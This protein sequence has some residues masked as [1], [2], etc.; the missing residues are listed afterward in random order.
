MICN[1]DGCT[2][3][4]RMLGLMGLPNDTTMDG[5]SFHIIEE[6]IGP[7]MRQ[8]TDEVLL[9]N[10][11]EEVRLSSDNESDFETWKRSIDPLVA[12]P[13][14]PL[15]RHPRI[16]AS[17]DTAWQQKGSGHTHNSPSGHSLMF[18]HHTRKPLVYA[19]K[20]KVCNYCNAFKKKQPNVDV[21]PHDCCKNHT[22]SS[23]QMEPD[24][25]LQ[26]IVSLFDRHQCVLNMLCCDDDSSVRADCRWSN[27]DFLAN[28]PPGTKLPL[29]KK[30]VGKNKGELQ[31]RPN[32]G[33]LPA[34][35]PEPF[36]VADP[37][38]RRK[39]LTGELI[40]LAKSKVETKMTMTRMD[41]TRIGK[42]FGYMA[43]SLK[44]TPP[45]GFVDKGKAV[46]EH[47]FDNHEYCGTWCAR[48]NESV[49]RRAATKKY[50][51]CKTKDA[52]LYCLLE[53]ILSNYITFERL[54]DIAHGMDTNCCEAFNNF[55]TWF[56]PKNKV[57]C[58]SRSLWNR[59]GLCI[60][61]SSLGYLV[62]F[63]RLY[64]KMGI[65]M[66]PNVHNF[67]D[68]K[69]RSR[70]KRL[71]LAKD[72]ASKKKRNKRKY[73]KL[74]EY[75]TIARKERSKRDGYRTGMN[76][77]T[78]E[79]GPEEAASAAPAAVPKKRPPRQVSVCPHPFC[80]KRGHKTTKSKH[81]L[82]NPHRLQREGLESA[83]LAA[84]AAVEEDDDAVQPMVDDD[85]NTDAA[86][87]L[88]EYE[89][90]PFEEFEEDL[91]YT[92]GTWSEDDDGNVV[93]KSGV[94]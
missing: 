24:S 59:V 93:L 91:F 20:S 47:H 75:T 56:A 69:N 38:H 37:N 71:A 9:E 45:E 48:Q 12:T 64:K 80:G 49:E 30:K 65:T 22:G 26:L 79:V 41:A 17:N 77:D 4:A 21:P 83:C 89:S 63:Q 55:M 68:V 36:F 90:Q 27:P 61:I 73:D 84:V 6:R 13:P 70:S 34:R 16:N 32:K 33:K 92:S 39:Q 52:K 78:V 74:V 94:I 3:A 8:L 11:I 35:I 44:G 29:V 58:G 88:A 1:G 53:G 66:E 81:C 42:N 18:G 82:A 7:L 46:L 50:Y 2:E 15:E 10:L 76:L 51:R 86:N 62:Y 85:N 40:A 14:L 25:C 43:R 54:S 31:E 57:C 5:R 28:N 67:L 19:V 87:D 60:G 23:G 72:K